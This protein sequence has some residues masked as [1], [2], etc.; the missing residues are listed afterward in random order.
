MRLRRLALLLLV[1]AAAALA[2]ALPATGKDGVKATLTTLV[3]LGSPAGTQLKVVWTLAYVDEQGRR[4]PFGGGGI[5]VRLLSASGA[6]AETAFARRQAGRYAATVPVPKG[7]IRDIQVGI[8]GWVSG[9][10]GTRRSDVLF[11]ITNDPVPG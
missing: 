5:F 3:P 11:P 6:G 10:T 9:P 4:H 1:I 8:R 7:G 2:A